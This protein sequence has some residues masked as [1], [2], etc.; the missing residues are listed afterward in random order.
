MIWPPTIG[1][2]E[3]FAGADCGRAAKLPFGDSAGQR[4]IDDGPTV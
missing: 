2:R 3:G 1:G 4:W